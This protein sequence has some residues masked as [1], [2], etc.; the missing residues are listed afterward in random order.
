MY[1]FSPT[2][3]INDS[4]R[5][6]IS[7]G[8]DVLLLL[9][10]C[11]PVCKDKN[12]CIQDHDAFLSKCPIQIYSRESRTGKLYRLFKIKFTK[13]RRVEKKKKLIT[14][15]MHFIFSKQLKKKKKPSSCW[16][17][18][19]YGNTLL[20]LQRQTSWKNTDKWECY[21]FF[22]FSTKKVSKDIW[23]LL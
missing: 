11:P 13:Y 15:I 5:P 22:F 2:L 21:A 7:S 23:T 19:D 8:S 9:W 6:S 1:T 20:L 3:H 17:L 16:L 12:R 14:E 10:G 18:Y 4:K